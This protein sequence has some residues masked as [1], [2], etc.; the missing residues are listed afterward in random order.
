AIAMQPSGD[1]VV[2][3]ASNNQDGSGYGVYAQRFNAIGVKQGSE[4]ALNNFTTGNQSDVSIAMDSNGGIIAAW[5]SSGQEGNGYGI[6]AK[7]YSDSSTD[8]TPPILSGVN[9]GS[10]RVA[11]YQSTS[12]F[13]SQINVVFSGA[14]NLTEADNPSHWRLIRNGVDISSQI[15]SITS[16]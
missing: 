15:N 11:S 1:F 16:V 10:N 14:L 7:Q 6:Y 4:F 8:T 12:G 9:I 2:A 13:V 3:W 5:D